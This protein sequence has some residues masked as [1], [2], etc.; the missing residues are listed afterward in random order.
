MPQDTVLMHYGFFRRVK[1]V[2][3]EVR[4][5]VALKSME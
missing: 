5:E 4:E 3:V 2:V 1:A